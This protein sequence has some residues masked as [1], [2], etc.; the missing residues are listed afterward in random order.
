MALF[1]KAKSFVQKVGSAIKSVAQGTSRISAFKAPVIKKTTPTPTKTVGTTKPAVGGG[2]GGSW[3]GTRTTTSTP[4]KT[5]PSA[6][7]VTTSNITNAQGRVVS[8]AT[9]QNGRV[10][11]VKPVGSTIA[12]KSAIGTSTTSP[13]IGLPVTIAPTDVAAIRQLPSTVLPDNVAPTIGGTVDADAAVTGLSTQS[14]LTSDYL[15]KQL[16]IEGQKKSALM[17]YF[18]STKNIESREDVRQRL[19]GQYGIQSQLAEINSLQG[20]YNQ[21][22]AAMETE[23]NTATDMMASEGFISRRQA[24]V[25]RRYAP[26]LN[27]MAADINARTAILTQNRDLMNQAID[28][29]VAD[30]KFDLDRARM[31]YEANIDSFESLSGVY[32][33]AYKELLRQKET[34][35]NNSRED[36]KYVGE[37]AMKYPTA[38]IKPWDSISDAQQ[39][40]TRVSGISILSSGGGSGTGL[41]GTGQLISSVTGKPLTDAERLSQ[42]Y[43]SRMVS[44]S[45]I[46]DR[47]GSQFTGA[48]SY[49]GQL[50]PNILKSAER[51]QFE[52]AQR[53]FINAVLR[54]ESGAAIA[55]SEFKSA[56]QQYF[57]KPGDTAAVV[58]QKAR[59]RQ[60]SIDALKLSGGMTSQPTEND[61]LGLF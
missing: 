51:Q 37:L 9:I 17:D 45:S 56:A 16:E 44:S 61:P 25:E 59:N 34:E 20:A 58:A 60:V 14:Q 36:A 6:G 8:Q 41:V 43:A 27:R 33:D 55:E 1:A 18:D 22:K 29:V 12:Q 23:T 48:G 26:T 7:K 57:P 50:L 24:A 21:T 31:F 15:N 10:V 13:T 11:S 53:D 35:Y 39:K 32:K 40:A 28:D 49:I 54:R 42:G 52:Q 47:I 5:T 19:E 46:I 3:G 30:Q 38:N 2:G 4:I